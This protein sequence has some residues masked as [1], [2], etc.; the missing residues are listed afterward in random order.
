MKRKLKE[1]M[2]G[3]EYTQGA[4]RMPR[5]LGGQLRYTCLRGTEELA[6]E[7]LAYDSRQECRGTVFFCISGFTCDGHIF[8]R[9]ALEKGAAAL[10]VEKEELLPEEGVD[11]I[12]VLKVENARYALALM[13]AAWFG[14]PAKELITIGIT[15]TKGKT[16]TA[17]MV[18]EILKEAGVLSG[19]I[20]TIEMK[21][22][23]EV[24]PAKHT[25]PESY[26][27]QKTLRTMADK[28]CRVA[29]MEVSSQG[30]MLSRTE[31]F[32]FDYGI[33]MNL[34]PDH[35]G[36]KE[37]KSFQEYLECKA[38]LFQRCRQGILNADDPH[39]EEILI[40]HTCRVE[41]F[42]TQ[43]KGDWQGSRISYEKEQGKLSV[44]FVAEHRTVEGGSHEGTERFPVT[45]GIPGGFHVSN[46]LAAIAACRRLSL[47]YPTFFV[48]ET[49]IQS[50]LAGLRV[51]GRMEPVQVP[52]AYAVF[53]DYAH[54]AMSLK[55]MLRTVRAYHPRRLICMFGCGGNRS[56]LRRY[57]MGEVSAALADLTVITT[58][59]PRFEEPRAIMEDIQTGAAKAKG[60][61]VMIEDRKEAIRYCLGQARPGDVIVLAGKGHESYQEIQGVKYPMDERKLVEEILRES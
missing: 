33:F 16:T 17:Y 8:A 34:E 47:E 20:G 21:I 53:I 60:E 15:G 44:S 23:E 6:V 18:H 36:P 11:G 57:Q 50:A 26:V 5:P 54:N 10:V 2:Q 55:G 45:I 39:L 27:V 52:G 58:D 28:G 24:I 1:L 41:T 51:R 38:K 22:G 49:H 19:L 61:Y 29:V 59:N 37:H 7:G 9:E 43:G 3:L 12:T 31:G 32:T 56:K 48:R 4:P 14:H 13:S 46:A 40:S 35:I 42:G 30:L 25:T